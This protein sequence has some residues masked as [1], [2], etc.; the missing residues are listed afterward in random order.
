MIYLLLFSS[1]AYAADTTNGMA[2]FL[3]FEVGQNVGQLDGMRLSL[4]TVPTADHQQIFVPVHHVT[5]AFGYAL[6][7]DQTGQQFTISK[8][9]LTIT[10][11]IDSEIVH[12]KDVGM[13]IKIVLEAPPKRVDNYILMPVQFF[14]ACMHFRVYQDDASQKVLITTVGPGG[15]RIGADVMMS[16]LEQNGKSDAGIVIAVIDTGVDIS[17]PYLQNRIVQA[18]N[19]AESNDDVQDIRGHGTMVAG[20]IANCTPETVKIMPI[21]AVNN[22]E[23]IA[24]A[25]EYAT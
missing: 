19:I 9:S 23:N 2:T 21:K 4:D 14:K 10:F 18:Y 17:H 15:Q 25:I 11:S 6:S 24:Q 8:N 3:E 5:R 7:E 12:L 22:N 1:T 16:Y 20:I 13:D